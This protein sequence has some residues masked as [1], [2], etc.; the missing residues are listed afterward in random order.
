MHRRRRR[1]RHR[2]GGNNRRTSGRR[3]VGQDHPVHDTPLHRRALRRQEG[4]RGSAVGALRPT[5]STE[6][7][8]NE[9]QEEQAA[10]RVRDGIH[11]AHERRKAVEM[12]VAMMN[13]VVCP[14]RAFVQFEGHLAGLSGRF[15]T[16][17]EKLRGMGAKVM[18]EL[19]AFHT[20][21][22]KQNRET[23]PPMVLQEAAL[24]PRI[25]SRALH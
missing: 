25:R 17:C 23:F 13:V 20:T 5:A 19:V 15:A 7:D 16:G 24:I 21:N 8:A 4:R 9:A 11:D 22:F 10:A 14:D 12:V 2:R 1:G 18:D 3:V 6:A